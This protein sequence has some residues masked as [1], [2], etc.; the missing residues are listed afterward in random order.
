[1]GRALVIGV[2][3]MLERIF[4]GSHQV[5]MTLL[6]SQVEGDLDLLFM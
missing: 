4:L 6:I 3:S 2:T 5:I 1:M